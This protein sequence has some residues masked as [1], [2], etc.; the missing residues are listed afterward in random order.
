MQVKYKDPGRVT[1]SEFIVF[2]PVIFLM[3]ILLCP[4]QIPLYLIRKYNLKKIL[5]N[6]KSSLSSDDYEFFKTHENLLLTKYFKYN[7]CDL[8]SISTKIPSKEI[9]IYELNNNITILKNDIERRKELVK[10]NNK[11]EGVESHFCSGYIFQ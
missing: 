4:I 6:W 3:E 7:F 1:T 8:H 5:K 10:S 2:I 11:F 9:I